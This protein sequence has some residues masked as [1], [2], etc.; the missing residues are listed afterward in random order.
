MPDLIARFEADCQ[1][2]HIVSTRTYLVYIRDFAGS[3]NGRDLSHPNRDDLKAYLEVLRARKL[4]HS[5]LERAFA[6][7]VS[8]YDFLVAEEEI[9]ANPI[10]SFR[11]RYLKQYKE[12]NGHDARQLISVEDAARLVSSTLK[13]EHRAILL[14]LLK[15]GMRA[16]ELCSLDVSDVSLERGEVLLKPTAKRSNRLL[17]FD[18]ETARV[19]ASWLDARKHMSWAQHGALF[20]SRQGERLTTK[21]LTWIVSGCA[22]RV[23]LHDPESE[24]LEDKF[25]P[26]CARHW[27]GTHLLCAGM[28]RE[29]VQWLR[30]DAIKEAVDIYFHVDPEDV[31]RAYLA[32]IPQLGI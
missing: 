5:S 4:K 14:L 17:F 23:G 28:R 8:F 29:Y 25:T 22:E 7:L 26:H 15:T 20:P 31:R 3:L 10:Q 32:H 6:G 11:R 19:L 1:I 24:K 18:P 16:G 2:R 30:G 21:T 27:N 12:D 13:T 9:E